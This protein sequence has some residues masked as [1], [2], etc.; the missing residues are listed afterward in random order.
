[1]PG[2]RNHELVLADRLEV[3]RSQLPVVSIG[4]PAA[5][6]RDRQPATNR[7]E[8]PAYGA[9]LGMALPHIVEQ[10]SSRGDSITGADSQRGVHHV[11]GVAL[12]LPTLG[13]EQPAGPLTE[14][15]VHLGLVAR[16]RCG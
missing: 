13:P 10:R 6:K 2:E 15:R 8:G 4:G 16:C 11:D 5:R 9:K 7:R 12:I 1:M 14:Q 3:V